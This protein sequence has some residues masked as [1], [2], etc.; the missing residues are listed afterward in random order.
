M[1][2]VKG[3]VDQSR[4]VAEFELRGHAASS[5]SPVIVRLNRRGITWLSAARSA[6]PV[7]L[8]MASASSAVD[9]ALR[10][11]VRVDLRKGDER[12][13][14]RP[15]RDFDHLPLSAAVTIAR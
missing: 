1:I 3:I 15:A 6:S 4:V 12:H 14:A 13:S 11:V 10:E 8:A 2:C 5:T 7:R 9:V